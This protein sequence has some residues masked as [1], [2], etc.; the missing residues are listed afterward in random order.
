MLP[1]SAPP[2]MDGVVLVD[3]GRIA[4][5]GPWAEL[6]DLKGVPVVE[7]GSSVLMPGL[8][9]AH[10]HLDYTC[11]A[12]QIPPPRTFT[13]WIKSIVTAKAGLGYTDYAQSW[14]QGARQLLES[15]TTTVGDIEAVPELLP[16][17]LEATPLRVASHLEMTGVRS[18]REPGAIVEEAVRTA[19]SLPSRGVSHG[20]S[21]HA[22]YSTSPALLRLASAA[23]ARLVMHVAESSE[24]FEMYSHKRGVLHDWLRS[25]RD[26]S[27]TGLGS[28]VMAVERAGLLSPRLLAVH[29]NYTLP[30][31]AGLIA[32]RGVSVAHCPRSHFY[33]RHAAFP[34]REFNEAGVNVCLGTDSLASVV[35]VRGRPVALD[36]FEEMR[37][38]ARAQP[39]LGSESIVRMATMNGAAALGLAGRLGEL[40][41]G[42][43][44]D[45]ISIPWSPGDADPYDT[46]LHHSGRV[47]SSMIDGRW[48]FGPGS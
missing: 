31:E 21:P 38:L 9:N 4:G 2:I 30:G 42:S 26:M 39:G 17:V 27:D 3:G 45:M 8:V 33:F 44:A 6:A 37:C 7:L 40:R 36:L 28:P 11:L 18:G 41:V 1:V 48:V 32:R 24:E 46:A 12:G 43:L 16:E 15:G 20:L 10:C 34:F 47:S 22:L 19:S 23:G 25:Q 14:L 35:K 29:M 5:V 13:D